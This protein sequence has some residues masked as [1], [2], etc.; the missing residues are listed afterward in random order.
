[1]A[2]IVAVPFAVS[3]WWM[4]FADAT[5]AANVGA[6]FL[7][8]EALMPRHFG[9]LDDRFSPESWRISWPHVWQGIM[10]P[11]A[12]WW[13]R[14]WRRTGGGPRGWRR[15]FESDQETLARV[16]DALEGEPIGAFVLSGP[17]REHRELLGFVS[18]RCDLD[19]REVWRRDDAVVYVPRSKRA[20][21]VARVGG[22]KAPPVSAGEQ[23]AVARFVRPVGLGLARLRTDRWPWASFSHS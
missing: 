13:P 23:G 22:A 8:S 2:A 6:Q 4:H 1:M 10:H 16:L 18:A 3:L 12:R 7:R 20:Q 9:T 11:V 14:W 17:E 21:A 19:E 15:G 5:K